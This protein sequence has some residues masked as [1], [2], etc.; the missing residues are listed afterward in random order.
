V[1]IPQ[2]LDGATQGCPGLHTKYPM[3][4][5]W[6]TGL[7]FARPVPRSRY[8]LC[9]FTFISTIQVAALLSSHQLFQILF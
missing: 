1:T 5:E 9:D 3:P 7:Y 2:T 8:P 6:T 4:L